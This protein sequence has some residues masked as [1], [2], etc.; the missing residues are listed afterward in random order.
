MPCFQ[1]TI[2]YDEHA[3]SQFNLPH[4]TENKKVTTLKNKQRCG[5]EV[6]VPVIVNVGSR[7]TE[8]GIESTVGRIC[9]TGRFKPGVKKWGSYGWWQWWI[10][11]CDCR[12]I[13]RHE[14]ERLGVGRPDEVDERNRELIPERRWSTPKLTISYILATIYVDGKQRLTRDRP[15]ER[16]LRGGWTV[17]TLC[18]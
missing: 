7:L 17:I 1:P 5:S 9:E 15:K 4:G 11:I 16:V 12:R 8:W 2:W 10:K 6:M 14:I 3:S 18:R 13:E